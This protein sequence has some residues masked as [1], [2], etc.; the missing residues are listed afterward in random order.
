MKPFSLVFLS[1]FLL[2]VNAVRP[3]WC[4]DT[5][6]PAVFSLRPTAQV[7]SAGVFLHQLASEDWSGPANLL[8]APAPGLNQTLVLTR[9]RIMEAVQ[10][11]DPTLVLTN[12]SGPEQ[13]RVTRQVR[14]LEESELKDL[15]TAT[16]QREQVRDRGELELRLNRPWTAVNVPDEPLSVRILDLPIVG[17]TPN[18][19]LRFELRSEKE[20]IGTWQMAL[21]AR[22]WHDVWVARSAQPRGRLLRDADLTTE[23]RDLLTL[24]DAFSVVDMS[25]VSLEL[26]ENL[27]AGSPLLVRSVRIRPVIQRGK[28]LDAVIQQGPM[29]IAVKA[30]ALEDGVP[31]QLIRVRNA[32]S[33]REF[34]GKVQNE[35]T[36]IVAL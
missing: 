19:I 32:K 25:D 33:K 24:R 29:M 28:M 21:Q 22:V 3:A 26:A 15:L 1:A 36:V 18:F 9:A 13:I 23:R 14:R 20:V 5:S 4:A 35:T 7:T 2:S 11:L 8:I 6:G 30:E 34:R 16:L 31:G 10:K 12:W 17:V 27:S